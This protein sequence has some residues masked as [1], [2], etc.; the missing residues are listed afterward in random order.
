MLL[1][2]TASPDTLTEGGL[3]V[4][5]WV[6]IFDLLHA[7]LNLWL[8]SYMAVLVEDNTTYFRTTRLCCSALLQAVLCFFQLLVLINP[9]PWQ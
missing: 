2:V 4:A 8:S 7:N 3:L 1:P 5:E 9:R 6:L